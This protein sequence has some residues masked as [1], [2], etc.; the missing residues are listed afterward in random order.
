M[1]ENPD[2]EKAVNTIRENDLH[3][4]GHT[5]TTQQYQPSI[6]FSDQSSDNNSNSRNRAL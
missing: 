5:K 4:R 2:A 3:D 6:Y 1:D